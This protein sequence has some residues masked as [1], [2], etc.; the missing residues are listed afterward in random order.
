[1]V[2]V[3]AR[4][5]VLQTLVETQQKDP[6][7]K[8]FRLIGGTLVE[9]TVKEVIPSLQ[10]NNDGVRALVPFSWFKEKAADLVWM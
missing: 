3:L 7:R 4:R 1:M 9:R 6:Q 8:C 10:T 5:L 2:P